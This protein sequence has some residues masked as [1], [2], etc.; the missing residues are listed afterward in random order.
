MPATKAA[1]SKGRAALAEKKNLVQQGSTLDSIK[2]QLYEAHKCTK[3]LEAQLI[4]KDKTI[5]TLECRIERLEAR[6][7]QLQ[8]EVKE[9]KTKHGTTYHKFR[10][11]DQAMRRGLK[12]QDTLK[13]QVKLFKDVAERNRTLL[14]NSTCD[15]QYAITFLRQTNNSLQNQLSV[16]LRKWNENLESLKRDVHKK[17]QTLKESQRELK[18]K[19]SI[20]N[21]MSKHHLMKKGVFTEETRNVVHLLVKAGCSAQYINEVITAVLKSAGIQ[22]VGSISRTSVARIVQEGF[23]AAQIQLGHEMR[24]AK[25]VTFSTDG[26]GHHSI[27]YNS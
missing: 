22:P 8:T 15:S 3:D 21:R 18:P 12:K 19:A 2:N 5:A 25:G 20:S 26:T 17:N 4:L 6:Q 23:I 10:M 11:A 16:S 1:L 24:M 13:A 9:W 14:I 27:N 7:V